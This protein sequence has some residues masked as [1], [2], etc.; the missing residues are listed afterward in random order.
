MNDLFLPTNLLS[1][2]GDTGVLVL[3]VFFGALTAVFTL[4]MERRRSK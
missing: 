3:A 1:L 2:P 4:R